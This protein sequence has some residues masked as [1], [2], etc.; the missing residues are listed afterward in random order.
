MVSLTSIPYRGVIFCVQKIAFCS[1]A[2]YRRHGLWQQKK[3]TESRLFL[4]APSASNVTTTR[5]KTAKTQPT[6]WNVTSTADSAKSTPFTENLSKE[7]C[8]GSATKGKET[9]H[10]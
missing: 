10:F 6:D 8:H 1:G 9:Q 2:N 3:E 4:P 5:L 7:K